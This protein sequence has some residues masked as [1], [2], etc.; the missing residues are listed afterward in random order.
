MEKESG[1]FVAGGKGKTTS[2]IEAASEKVGR[3]L[4][5]LVYASR[6]TAKVDTSALQDGYQLYHHTFFFTHQGDW[7]V[8]QQGM[9]G[10]NKYA[11][12]YHW[13]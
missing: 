9:N 3:Y 13:A 5:G 4:S 8:V 1:L 12:R 7:A 6:L 11:R 2:E 10:T